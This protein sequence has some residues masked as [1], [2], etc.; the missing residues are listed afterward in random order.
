MATELP[1]SMGIKQSSSLRLTMYVIDIIISL[2]VDRIHNNKAFKVSSVLQ[3][4]VSLLSVS[5]LHILKIVLLIRIDP[6]S[7]ALWMRC[8]TVLTFCF[9]IPSLSM[10][11]SRFTGIAP[12]HPTVIVITLYLYPRY[13]FCN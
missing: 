7:A 6:R 11:C 8:V 12:K 10:F 3:F 1:T 4:R 2:S 5:V 9:D 13:I